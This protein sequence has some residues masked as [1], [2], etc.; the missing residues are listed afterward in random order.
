MNSKPP[1]RRQFST[2]RLASRSSPSNL[3][4]TCRLPIPT[5]A[6]SIS[7]R[8]RVLRLLCLPELEDLSLIL[9][10][11]E[12]SVENLRAFVARSDFRLKRLKLRMFTG[13]REQLRTIF[14]A[15]LQLEE[16]SYIGNS[17]GTLIPVLTTTSSAQPCLPNLQSLAF[18]T[19][20]SVPPHLLP[21]AEMLEFSAQED[22][23]CARVENCS[24]S[25]AL[26]ISTTNLSEGIERFEWLRADGTRTRI[27]TC[28][29]VNY[30]SVVRV[31]FDQTA[32]HC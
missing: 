5:S 12:E 17:T 9:R 1:M 19:D 20:N 27:V 30:L 25:F 32:E 11:G 23:G 2:S 13:M 18:A 14:S 10:F 21:L 26:Q 22:S 4:S 28:K 31:L 6:S 16:L 29:F 3:L 15:L 24:L 7:T 8:H